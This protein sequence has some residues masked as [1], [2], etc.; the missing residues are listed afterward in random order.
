[1]GTFVSLLLQSKPT[2]V[3]AKGKAKGKAKAKAKDLNKAAA[4][5]ED[6]DLAALILGSNRKHSIMASIEAKYG[7]GGYDDIDDE[8]FAAAQR[9]LA[10]KK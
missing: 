2:P 6:K 7:G 1:M 8:A 4:K 3:K 10:R 9:R 5:D